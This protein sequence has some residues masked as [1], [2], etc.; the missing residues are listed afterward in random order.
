MHA[1]QDHVGTDYIILRTDSS[2]VASEAI[3]HHSN[4][5]QIVGGLN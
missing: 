3:K 2:S 5:F 4:I 1:K